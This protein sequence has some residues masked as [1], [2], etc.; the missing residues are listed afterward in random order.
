MTEFYHSFPPLIS[1]L[2]RRNGS[3]Q[4]RL[5]TTS[6]QPRV[7]LARLRK[8]SINITLLVLVLVVVGR[9]EV[10]AKLW[11]VASKLLTFFVHCAVSSEQ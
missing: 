2:Q 5:S 1:T 3:C 10:T 9:G 11:R 6:H 4:N 7:A 8:I